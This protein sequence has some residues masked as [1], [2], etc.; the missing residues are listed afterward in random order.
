MHII[1]KP[2]PDWLS[3][4]NHAEN[5]DEEIAGVRIN[6]NEIRTSVNIPVF[7]SIENVQEA[8]CEDAQLH[9]LRAYIA[10]DWPHKK[11]KK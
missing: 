11:K 10:Q 9:E 5:R 6:M 3:H 2:G 7:M 4:N 8:T 1:Y